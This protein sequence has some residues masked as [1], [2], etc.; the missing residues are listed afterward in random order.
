MGLYGL[1]IHR[2]GDGISSMGGK[3][4]RAVATEEGD[5]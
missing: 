4:A 5:C 3:I 2:A 1:Q